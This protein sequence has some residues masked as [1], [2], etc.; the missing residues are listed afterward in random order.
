MSAGVF[1][2][3]QCGGA[4]V[5]A[6]H[7]DILIAVLVGENA[8]GRGDALNIG[9]ARLVRVLT[10]VPDNLPKADEG[11]IVQERGA[12]TAVLPNQFFKGIPR[13]FI[14]NEDA[15]CATGKNDFSNMTADTD[16]VPYMEFVVI[17][18][19]ETCVEAFLCHFICVSHF[20]TLLFRN[21]CKQKADS[22]EDESAHCS[23]NYEL[24][25]RN[26]SEFNGIYRTTMIL[27]SSQ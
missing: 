12:V 22:S 23:Q 6:A 2:L 27:F 9:Q 5:D 20:N 17:G 13:N 8:A 14:C 7:E 1:A 16:I 26:L 11:V 4:T 21:W 10:Q 25:E 15:E 24:C 3:S 19:G 18:I